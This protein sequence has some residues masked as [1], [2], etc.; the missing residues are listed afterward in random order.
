MVSQISYKLEYPKQML[1]L[2]V[3]FAILA[4]QLV[5]LA[6]KKTQLKDFLD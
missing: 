6:N 2:K 3:N 4:S 5:V 1:M